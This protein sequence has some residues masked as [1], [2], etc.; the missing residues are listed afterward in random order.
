MRLS[1]VAEVVLGAEDYDVSF[2]YNGDVAVSMGIY[3]LPDANALTV[4][5]DIRKLFPD[6]VAEL[7][8]GVTGT[9]SL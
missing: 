1:D 5:R 8:P 7:P 9:H 6:I 2:A 3:T 4:I